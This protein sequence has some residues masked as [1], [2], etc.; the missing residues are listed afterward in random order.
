[1]DT[2]QHPFAN[3]KAL[4]VTRHNNS[5]HLIELTRTNQYRNPNIK[6]LE[7]QFGSVNRPKTSAVKI[8]K[9]TE[10]HGLSAGASP[11]RKSPLSKLEYIKAL[12]ELASKPDLKPEI[13][14]PSNEK[15]STSPKEIVVKKKV[16][17]VLPVQLCIDS[18]NLPF[19][20]TSLV[21]RESIE[22]TEKICPILTS[23]GRWKEWEHITRRC[24]CSSCTCGNHICPSE[25]ND[26][27][28]N[29]NI[30]LNEVK[31]QYIKRPSMRNLSRECYSPI[32][33]YR[34]RSS[35]YS[36]KTNHFELHSKEIAPKDEIKSGLESYDSAREMIHYDKVFTQV[37]RSQVLGSSESK[38][39]DK[40][41]ERYSRI[42]ESSTRNT[43]LK[44]SSQEPVRDRP[45]SF[46]PSSP[47]KKSQSKIVRSSMR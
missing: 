18:V 13:V 44:V 4:A 2:K 15:P 30:L 25:T 37:A 31:N 12:K 3:K 28:K 34:Y 41:K 29:H 35:L 19:Q 20:G 1:M 27:T 14:N 7:K 26:P 22:I 11:P 42:K 9:P 45:S 40:G 5:H 38:S 21:C 43:A 17:I 36:S 8:K 46:I 39:L 23:P 10:H 16:E 6:S 24:N 32:R 47:Y 33:F